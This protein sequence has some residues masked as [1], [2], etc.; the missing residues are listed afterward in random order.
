MFLMNGRR[1]FFCWRLK[2]NLPAFVFDHFLL[3]FLLLCLFPLLSSICIILIVFLSLRFFLFSTTISLFGFFLQK[4]NMIKSCRPTNEWRMMIF[5]FNCSVR[6]VSRDRRKRS[7][8]FILRMYYYFR[9]FFKNYVLWL[10]YF[11]SRIYCKYIRIWH[12]KSCN[13]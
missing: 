2:E 10:E 6:G 9:L 12:N 11:L 5:H 1:V 13:V 3:L 7:M 8:L 4:K